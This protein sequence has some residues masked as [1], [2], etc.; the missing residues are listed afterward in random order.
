MFEQ[1]IQ[2]ELIIDG[3]E[4]SQPATNFMISLAKFKWLTVL[5]QMLV[6]RNPTSYVYY[7]FRRVF[8]PEMFR[9]NFA[10]VSDFIYHY[11]DREYIMNLFF[12][13]R[14]SIDDHEES[15]LIIEN[16]FRLYF[17]LMRLKD[18]LLYDMDEK[19]LNRILV[20][21]SQRTKAST[22]MRKGIG[23]EVFD[24]LK[25]VFDLSTKWWKRTL[26]NVVK[27]RVY[28]IKEDDLI[29]RAILKFFADHSSQVE[30]LKDDILLTQ[31]FPILPYCK[32]SS[33][34]PKNRFL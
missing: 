6:G 29:M 18:N 31:Y 26:R 10:Y 30:I 21:I 1:T 27:E 9:L 17:L 5:L 11:H 28:F 33:E 24:F 25:D 2:N 7:L 4:V 3:V 8:S 13:Y 20:L 15:P 32:F 14:N 16:G 23:A 19:Y 34:E 22:T 12:K